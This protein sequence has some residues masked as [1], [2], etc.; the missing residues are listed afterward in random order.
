MKPVR[1]MILMASESRM[2][3]AEN[4]GVGKGVS[5]LLTRDATDFEGLSHGYADAPGRGQAAP[6]MAGHGVDRT[7]SEREQARDAFADKVLETTLEHWRSGSYDRL[8]VAAPPR[9]LG[10]L[11]AAL[12][13][14]LVS[15]L[16]ADLDKDL[17]KL[18]VIDLPRHLESVLA[19]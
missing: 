19:V 5:E 16:S 17:T 6:G 4:A 12:P 15:A 14:P 11:R 1:T 2:R 8:I 3:L 13:A 9:M 7:T 18:P 10:T